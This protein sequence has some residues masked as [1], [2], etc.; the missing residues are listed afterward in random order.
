MNQFIHPRQERQKSG[1]GYAMASSRHP[2]YEGLSQQDEFQ[3][4]PGDGAETLFINL[5]PRLGRP[6]RPK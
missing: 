2:G 4:Q 5:H 3:N 6:D 1:Q